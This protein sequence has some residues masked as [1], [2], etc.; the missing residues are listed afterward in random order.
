MQSSLPAECRTPPLPLA[1]LVGAPDVH[2]DF[3][4]WASQVLRPPLVAVAVAEPNEAVLTRF[5][6]ERGHQGLPRHE[7]NQPPTAASRRAAAAAAVSAA[8]WR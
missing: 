4:L 6:G 3:G 5:F 2:R 1:A 7:A 8:A